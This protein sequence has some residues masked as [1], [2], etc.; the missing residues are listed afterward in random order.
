MGLTGHIGWSHVSHLLN[1]LNYAGWD[2]VKNTITTIGR[3]ATLD[4]TSSIYADMINKRYSR[5]ALR[6]VLSKIPELTRDVLPGSHV[7][8]K[9]EDD[10]AY[11]LVP[12]A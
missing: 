1:N 9:S 7:I 11:N 4:I 5:Y 12:K 6:D 8:R 2:T 10:P 3:G